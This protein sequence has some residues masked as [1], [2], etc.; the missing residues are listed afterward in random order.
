MAYLPPAEVTKPVVTFLRDI[1]H[2]DFAD[3]EKKLLLFLQENKIPVKVNM[4]SELPEGYVDI[5]L[6]EEDGQDAVVDF[7][8]V[9]MSTYHLV[10]WTKYSLPQVD[11]I[12]YGV[13]TGDLDQD[14]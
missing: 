3:N 2:T 13:N 7:G 10:G 8:V 14:D 12:V 4:E 6:H 5:S 1:E 9:G 11:S